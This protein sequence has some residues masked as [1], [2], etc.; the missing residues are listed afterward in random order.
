MD[1]HE[2]PQRKKLPHAIP[3]WVQ[4]G[5]RHFITVNLASRGSDKLCRGDIPM[6]LLA[7]A[8]FYEEISR[9][10]LWVMLVMPDHVHFIAT[11][12]LNRGIRETMK[13]WKRY[14]ATYLGVDWQTDFF[15]HRLRNEDAFLEKA[16]YIRMNPVRK[17]LV[18]TPEEWP[19]VIDRVGLDRAERDQG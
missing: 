13:A 10:H 2:H 19:W 1:G 5:A 14:Q 18:K 6:A 7:S 15:E 16:H 9:W 12:N 4:Q 17:G 3:P 8:R 11:F